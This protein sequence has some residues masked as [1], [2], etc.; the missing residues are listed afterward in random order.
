MCP[1]SVRIIATIKIM[2]SSWARAQTLR[3]ITNIKLNELSKQRATS[4]ENKDYLLFAA[5]A[6]SD[7][8]KKLRALLDRRKA[9]SI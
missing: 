1:G 8:S 2:N 9:L 7:L 4:E 3:S 6:V 5:G